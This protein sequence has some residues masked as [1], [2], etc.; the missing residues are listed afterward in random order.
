MNRIRARTFCIAAAATLLMSATVLAETPKKID[1]PPGDLATALA[2][3]AR[4][5]GIELMY[6]SEQ[7]K[8]LR[9][10][11]VRGEYTT[12]TAA[13]KLLEGTKLKL[14]VHERGGLL[15]SYASPPDSASNGAPLAELRLARTDEAV[16]QT[17]APPPAAEEPPAEEKETAEVV[18]TGSRIGRA[19]D[20]SSLPVTRLTAED[21]ALTGEARVAEVISRLPYNS[22]GPALIS[23]GSGGSTAQGSQDVNL[24]GLGYGRTLTLLN[25]RRL[26]PD[27][28]AFAFSTNLNFIPMAAVDRIEVLRSGGSPVYGS[29]AL[30]GVVNIV[31]KEDFQGGVVGVQY[32]DNLGVDANELTINGTFGAASENGSI[33]VSLEKR[34]IDPVRTA[35]LDA[36]MPDAT[37]LG[38]GFISNGFPTTFMIRDIFGDGTNILSPNIASA[39]CAANRVRSTAGVTR[40]N[41][42]TSATI[43][44]ANTLECRQDAETATDFTAGSD[45]QSMF[46]RARYRVAENFSV[47]ADVLLAD[48]DTSSKVTPVGLS[49]LTMAANN[50]NNPTFAAT[51]GSPRYGVT[52]PRV[53]TFGLTAPRMTTIRIDTRQ[54]LVAGGFEWNGA[55]GNL[56]GY[57]HW[58]ES[59]SEQRTLNTFSTSAV[60]AAINGGTLNPFGPPESAL[61]A[62]NS[63]S[64]VFLRMP[65][66]QVKTANLSWSSTLPVMLPGGPMRYSL[67]AEKR[68][69]SYVETG[70]GSGAAQGFS[71]AFFLPANNRRDV[72]SM[73]AEILVPL[74][75]AVELN[76]ASRWDSYDL[77]DFSE[78]SHRLA[79]RW[80]VSPAV[81]LRASLT[82][83]IAAPNLYF[84]GSGSAQL[85]TSVIDT[86]RCRQANNNPNDPRCQPTPVL[87]TLRGGGDVGPET[88]DNYTAGIIW[89]AS[90]ALTLALDLWR[91]EVD[92]QVANLANQ[93]VVN[94]EADGVNLADYSVSLERDSSGAIISL[95]SGAANIPGFKTDGVDIEARWRHRFGDRGRFNSSALLTWV[96]SFERP[97]SPGSPVL[98]AVGYLNTPEWKASWTN[99]LT[100]GSVMGAVLLSYVDGFQGRT[101]ESAFA[102]VASPRSI[103]SFMTVDASVTWSTP[104]KSQLYI[105]MRN[106]FDEQPTVNRVIYGANS[107]DVANSSILG[108]MLVMRLTHDF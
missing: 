98:D 42:N 66:G 11:G 96:N 77:P 82:Q 55:R 18:V 19:T 9:T 40:V 54:L 45:L 32:G 103:D 64:G 17:P 24:R 80:R 108:R 12:Q 5:S 14:K 88:A 53:V 1:V 104:W 72:D 89:N 33:L 107:F 74:S 51:P 29:D 76:W 44:Y 78:L 67:G 13:E 4:Q 36:V 30:G 102:N 26:P 37:V 47:F 52:G 97:I 43:V 48:F 28:A 79:A 73:F 56:A 83:G 38:A 21:I 41:P 91:V 25:G 93:T 60:Q 86:R 106:V 58:A 8:G 69:E 39:S 22:Q 35:E 23:S 63:A 46:T 95:T 7:L 61:A 3:L 20:D 16:A 92:D 49:G 57:Y 84:V 50:P 68:R 94:L 85:T 90:E 100:V 10:K 99:S 59:E 70:E 65:T 62:F 75:E 87:Q 2:Q 34:R 71:G 105:G 31:L 101:P 6:S 27:G 15:I 81:T